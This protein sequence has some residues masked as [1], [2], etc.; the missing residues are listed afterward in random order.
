[1]FD[2]I[3]C[4]IMTHAKVVAHMA[5]GRVRDVAAAVSEAVQRSPVTIC[6]VRRVRTC[7]GRVTELTQIGVVHL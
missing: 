6:L 5:Q 3:D 7:L 2:H 1:M 4:Y